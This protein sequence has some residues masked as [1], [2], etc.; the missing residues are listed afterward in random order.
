MTVTYY[1][2]IVRSSAIYDIAFTFLLAIP[3]LAAWKLGLLTHLHVELALAGDFP[4]FDAMHLFFV[5]LLGAL[6]IV[7]SWLR[8]RH[9]QPLFGLYDSVAR[10]AFSFMMAYALF[11]D[12]GTALI[13]FFLLPE[14]TW[15]VYQLY[16]YK[17]LAKQQTA[18]KAS[19]A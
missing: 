11:V 2:K 5:H 19:L 16:G 10:F 14:L 1:Q 6:V 13:W 4:K 18:A 17:R 7:W 3:G 8:I 12:N 15:G 9:P